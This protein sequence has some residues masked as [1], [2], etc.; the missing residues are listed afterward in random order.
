[1]QPDP[2]VR[3]IRSGFE[4]SVHVGHVAVCDADGTLVAFAGDPHRP[5]F[6]RSST[7]PLQAAVSLEAIG[8]DEQLPDGE[9]AVMCASHN[10]E[11][12]HV[13]AVR[14]LLDRAG[15]GEDAL[16]CPPSLPLDQEA[17]TGVE[18]PRRLLHNCSGKHAGM[19]LAC[20]RQGWDRERY[21]DL[22]HPLQ[23]R[24]LEAVRQAGDVADMHV[25]VDGCG[26]PVHGMPLS[27]LATLYARLA[28]PDRLGRLAPH[29]GRAAGAMAAEPYLVAGRNRVDTAVMQETGSLLVKGGAEGLV[30]A[31]ALEPGW[32]V[33]VKVHDGS[34]RAAGP[35][36]LRTLDRLGLILPKHLEALGPFAR[37][38]VLG[39]GRPVGELVA[40]F[41]LRPP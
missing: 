5:V 28:R 7:K 9:V 32:G 11:S 23:D 19:L 8:A 39:G 37:P 40:S 13:E 4:E 26:V 25:G 35:A 1:M 20:V 10:A 18:A 6:A 24:V 36:L 12:V 14:R 41:D 15:L 27:A 21:R 29:L 38:P 34:H 16:L 17:A 31:A 33:A 30:C 22:S 2:L 3:V